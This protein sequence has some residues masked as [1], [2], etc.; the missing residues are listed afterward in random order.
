M[1]T[2]YTYS[3]RI[4]AERHTWLFDSSTLPGLWSIR[5]EHHTEISECNNTNPFI[6]ISFE[7]NPLPHTQSQRKR[8][9]HQGAIWLSIG[10]QHQSGTTLCLQKSSVTCHGVSLPK[11]RSLHQPTTVQD[12]PNGSQDK[13]QES[14]NVQQDRKAEKYISIVHLFYF[15]FAKFFLFSYSGLL[16]FKSINLRRKMYN[17]IFVDGLQ[18][19]TAPFL[20]FSF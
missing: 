8:E 10:P 12:L 4:H 2:S 16:L 3:M 6:E 1:D 14:W 20:G 17:A 7:G 11:P 5:L 9:T 19:N 13:F 18:L 15:R